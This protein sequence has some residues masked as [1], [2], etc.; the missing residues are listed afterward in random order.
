MFPRTVSRTV[1]A[2]HITAA[3]GHLERDLVALLDYAGLVDVERRFGV[4]FGMIAEDFGDPVALVE[5]VGRNFDFTLVGIGYS[6]GVPDITLTACAG[7]VREI[8]DIAGDADRVIPDDG[9]LRHER[10]AFHVLLIFRRRVAEHLQRRE[11]HRH[12]RHL[13]AAGAYGTGITVDSLIS[14]GGIVIH[15]ARRV[16]HRARAH[17]H[18]I[19]ADVVLR[20]IVSVVKPLRLLETVNALEIENVGISSFHACRLK[21]S[22]IVDEHLLF[23]AHGGELP[24]EI[25]A[26]G[27]VAIHKVDLEALGPEFGEVFGDALLFADD[28]GPCHPEDDADAPV[29]GVPDEVFD[30]NFGIVLPDVEFL[31]PTL[32]KNHIF[33]AVLR[34]EIDVILIALRIAA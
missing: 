24:E 12:H 8:P 3:L 5:I 32:V 16:I 11:I 1:E 21:H 18:E 34:G 30:V 31:A 13:A 25:D 23:G 20:K 4:A 33:N 6:G 10:E 27:V 26:L 15:R 28:L 22:V 17:T 2:D 9:R 14:A 7:G 19:N 29:L